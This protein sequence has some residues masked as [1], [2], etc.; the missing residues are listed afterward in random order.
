MDD[1]VSIDT[2][3]CVAPHHVVQ[4]NRRDFPPAEVHVCVP[5]ISVDVLVAELKLTLERSEG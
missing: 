4:Q 1:D 3:V 2:Q 5:D